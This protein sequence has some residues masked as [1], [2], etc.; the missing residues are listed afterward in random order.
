MAKALALCGDC[1]RLADY[2]IEKNDFVN[3][4][5]ISA[6]RQMMRSETSV[7]KAAYD[8][9]AMVVPQVP[10]PESPSSPGHPSVSFVE[11][12][13]PKII[14]DC[15]NN[16]LW[17][18]IS[19]LVTHRI[20][21][22]RRVV[23]SKIVLEARQ[24]DRTRH[25]LV[26]ANTLGLLDQQYQLPSPPPD[27]IDFF[28]SLLPLLADKLCRRK[29]TVLWLVLRLG[30][31]NTTIN[32]AVVEAL[33]TCY[34]KQDVTIHDIFVEVE[35]LRRLDH[36]PTQPSYAITRLIC[37]LLPVLAI[38]HAR[39]KKVSLMIG[40]LDHAEPTVSNGCLLACMKIVDSTIENRACLH[41]EFSK[42]NFAKETSLKLCDYAMPVF[43]KD[44][45]AAGDFTKIAKLL[46]HSERRIR[47]AAH[48]VWNDVISNTPSARAKI[49][50]DDLIGVIFELCRSPYEDC[51]VLGCQSVPHMAIEVAKAGTA[52]TRQLISLLNNPRVDLRRAALKGIHVICESNNANCDVLLSADVF[53]ELKL[54]L[55]TNPHDG[56]ETAHKILV[57]LAPFLSKS[58]DACS[59]L[60][61]L[62]E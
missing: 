7:V 51:V 29:N 32:T 54:A 53:D 21:S 15:F 2:L 30:D 6:L 5:A 45:A 49:V 43:C 56:L 39:K 40:F 55:Q 38:P 60:L 35:L 42:L 24:S 27:V 61:E 36:P 37:E 20:D 13:A 47:F 62:I 41:A 59:G 44:W 33:R 48:R 10:L 52:F 12:M 19:P 28:V 8:A 34:M 1:P 23:L 25:G 26:E 50:R 58:S 3:Q 18:N 14:G 17:N 57:R 4:L 46:S 31:S 22:I 9:L 16:G 11:E